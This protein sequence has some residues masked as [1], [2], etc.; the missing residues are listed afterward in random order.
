M[1]IA[2]CTYHN[3]HFIN[4][5]IYREEAIKSLGHELV[6]VEDRDYLLPG[7]VRQFF[8]FLQRWD[9]KR[10]NRNFIK[11]AEYEKPDLWIV[12]GGF[13]T[14]PS[15]VQEIK[16]LGIPVILWTTDVPKNFQNVIDAAPFYNRIF[17]AGS[18]AIDVLKKYNITDLRLIPFGC[19][20]QYHKSVK[21]T[22]KDREQYEKDI[23][24]VGSYYPNR[25]KILEVLAEFNIGIWGPYWNNL[26][27]DSPLK[28]KVISRKINYDE[29]VKIYSAA[30]IVIVVHYQ[31]DDIPCHQVSP[32]L[33][34]AMACGSFVLVDRQKDVE[35]LFDHKSCLD[36]FGDTKELKQK[37]R[38]YL[39]HMQERKKMADEGRQVVIE[40]HT[41]KHRMAQ[42]IK[43][44]STEKKYEKKN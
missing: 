28:G 9:L 29:W 13:T 39:N 38:Y 12:V 33:F 8:S 30:K 43:I 27:K 41:F 5:S 37:V 2:L 19:D 1:K 36:F 35:L 26:R 7:R 40:Q 14:L 22:Q 4:T 21:L 16:S 17:C 18:E 32:K 25:E 31:D 3:P 11:I 34:E 24:F 15:T 23:V 6:A 44:V 20:P 42:I 10:M